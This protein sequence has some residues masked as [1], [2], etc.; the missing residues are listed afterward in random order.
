MNPP[1]YQCT[2]PNFHFRLLTVQMMWYNMCSYNCRCTMASW[3]P[4]RE[5]SCFLS[6][7][8]DGVVGTQ[9]NIDCRQDFCK[10]LDA[11][12]SAS[13]GLNFHFTGSKSEGLNLPGSDED[14]MIDMNDSM[15]MAA[16]Q[17]L[18]DIREIRHHNV[19]LMCTE[20]IR[21]G[22]ALLRQVRQKN[23]VHILMSENIDNVPYLSSNL[24]MNLFDFFKGIKLFS[25]VNCTVGRTGPSTEH[26]SE[27]HD[28]D[29]SGIDMV[30]S[31]RCP[32]WPHGAQEWIERPREYGWPSSRDMT[33]IIEFGCHLVP[34]GHP[35][36]EMKDTEWRISF[37]IAER[38]LVWSFN[39]VQIQCYAVMKIVLKEYINARC[40]PHNKALCSYFIKTFLFWK[41][42][43]TDAHFWIPENF[44][45]CVKYL[46][47]EFRKCISK[48]ELRHY[49]FPMF[50]L[51]SIK[52]TPAAWHEIL[53]L[54]DII[55]QS[56][57]SIFKDCKTLRKT[58][59]KYVATIEQSNIVVHES[60]RDSFLQNDTRM[61]SMLRRIRQTPSGTPLS[62]LPCT[63]DDAIRRVRD[64]SC[65]TPLKS[66]ALK[67]LF[68]H[69]ELFIYPY[70]EDVSRRQMIADIDEFH[71]SILHGQWST[72][73]STSGLWSAII[74]VVLRDYPSALTTVNRVLSQIPSFALYHSQTTV[75]SGDEAKRRYVDIFLNADTTPKIG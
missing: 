32:F 46:F 14:Y 55:I 15:M 40:Q 73:I 58:W 13:I 28:K 6:H 52:P 66:L 74:Q 42:E 47:I 53:Q 34:I 69:K 25:N 11:Y 20:N 67:Y 36:S 12:S 18:H 26:W 65:K 63:L 50:N 41:F 5:S 72:D 75:Q 21:P 2:S 19:Y 27:Y 24:F 56:D 57:V 48:G 31:I 35:H 61:M 62:I 7:L 44:R 70:A 17:S 71:Q 23:F 30:Y 33:A 54:L 39:K 51:L 8:L 22:F 45:E 60:R 4:E 37:S 16:V 38:T 59:S 10:I 29:D 1:N 3:S 43:S 64:L 49:F 9:Y 68:F